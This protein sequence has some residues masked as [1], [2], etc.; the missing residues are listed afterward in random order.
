MWHKIDGDCNRVYNIS[1]KGTFLWKYKL[2]QVYEMKKISLDQAMHPAPGL[3]PRSWQ[4]STPCPPPCPREQL[5]KT[6]TQGN[7]C[8]KGKDKKSIYISSAL[9][10]TQC[11][12]VCRHRPPL[13]PRLT[14]QVR[15]TQRVSSDYLSILYYSCI[16]H[17][18]DITIIIRARLSLLA[19]SSWQTSLQPTQRHSGKHETL[20][21][22]I[23]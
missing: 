20:F 1:K 6:C 12:K 10:K 11:T 2:R 21:T 8:F 16:L 13:P 19:L 5:Q 15:V 7:L 22:L 18:Q 14:K 3:W 17:F 23:Y 9:L 4:C